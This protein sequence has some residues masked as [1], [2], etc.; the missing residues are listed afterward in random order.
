VEGA[1]T[2]EV[3]SQAID[4]NLEWTMLD[5]NYDDRSRRIFTGPIF[6][7]LWWGNYD[8][9]YRT[10]PAATGTGASLPGASMGRGSSSLPGATFAASVVGGV[11]TFSGKVI[12][13][14]NTF[15]SKVTNVTNPPPPPTTSTYHGGGGGGCA[16]ACACAGCACACAGGGR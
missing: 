14:L 11:Q 7:P 5:R 1:Q 10:M 4:Q 13:D 9:V 3:K 16:C 6:I 2:P 8:P 12:G 15:T